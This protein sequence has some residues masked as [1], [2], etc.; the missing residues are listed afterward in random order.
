MTTGLSAI[1]SVTLEAVAPPYDEGQLSNAQSDLWPRAW[2]NVILFML[3][4]VHWEFKTRAARI[5]RRLPNDTAPTSGDHALS[6]TYSAA[7]VICFTVFAF[8]KPPLQEELR[9]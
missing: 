5:I 3:L 8:C 2:R 1:L 6:E 4:S 9:Q 7:L